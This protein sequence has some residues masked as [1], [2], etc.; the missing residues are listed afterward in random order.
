MF[1]GKPAIFLSCSHKHKEQVAWRFRDVLHDVGIFGIVVED[2]PRPGAAWSAD[3]KVDEY[4]RVSDAFV[5][6]CTPDDE[7]ANGTWWPRENIP[8]EIARARGMA[9]L[10]HKVA[11]LKTADVQLPSNLGP[12]YDHMD[13]DDLRPALDALMRQLRV[14]DFDVPTLAVDVPSGVDELHDAAERAP[15]LHLFK[16]GDDE[17][18][19]RR[20]RTWMMDHTKR[21]QE[22]AVGSVLEV[23]RDTDRWT[24][25]ENAAFVLDYLA[26][27][28][29]QLFSVA[30]LDELSRHR[31]FTVR[32]VAATILWT[33]AVIA[34]GLAPLDIVVRLLVAGEDWYVVTPAQRALQLLALSRSDAMQ[35]LIDLAHDTEKDH[36]VYAAKAFADIAEI[37]PAIVPRAVVEELAGNPDHELRSHAQRALAATPVDTGTEWRHAFAPFTMF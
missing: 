34:P 30:L 4:L 22:E 2:L 33:A 21:E 18:N 11:V 3:E 7:H 1:R 24:A 36:R 25:A 6:L 35:V 29:L 26:T 10:Q 17:G 14:W 8:E 19:R 23:L 20:I 13:L 16:L 27:V 31:D 32:S 28:D 5:A 9:H 12:A 15:L 37:R